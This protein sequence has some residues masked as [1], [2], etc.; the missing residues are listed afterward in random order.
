M[1]NDIEI[2]PLVSI[3]VIAYNSEKYICETLD[4][5]ID[6]TYENIEIIISDDG[7]SDS[8][9]LKCKKWITDRKSNVEIT[10]IENIEN[11]GIT[12]NC[13]RGLNK[14]KGEWIKFIAADDIIVPTGISDLISEVLTIKNNNLVVV[15][16]EFKTFQNEDVQVYPDSFTQKVISEKI[17]KKQILAMLIYFGNTAPGA[18]INRK[19][20]NGVGGFDESY[21]LL[22]DIPLWYKFLI[23]G[24]CFSFLRKITVLYRIHPNQAT[25]SSLSAKLAT[26]L[27]RFNKLNRKSGLIKNILY[28]HH[29]LQ[30]FTDESRGDRSKILM[31]IAKGISPIKIL[32]YLHN[33]FI[34]Y[35]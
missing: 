17:S 5:C 27:R 26:D 30:I 11:T 33:K 14:A 16:S 28:Y 7:S 9:L 35:R 19:A 6:Q 32:I 12:K 10:I 3:V 25:G 20:I 15:F 31:M 23:N 29:A 8:T 13:N 4:S 18:L 34:N 21:F 24:H 2:T 1:K 22:E